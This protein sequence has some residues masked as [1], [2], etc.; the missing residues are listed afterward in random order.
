MST[1]HLFLIQEI[2]FQ[3]RAQT[4][5]SA[6]SLNALAAAEHTCRATRVQLIALVSPQLVNKG[7]SS[8]LNSP[9]SQRLIRYDRQVTGMSQKKVTGVSLVRYCSSLTNGA[10]SD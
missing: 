4:G 8:R 2:C 10:A 5:N 3:R 9:S 1:L 6:Q 7:S